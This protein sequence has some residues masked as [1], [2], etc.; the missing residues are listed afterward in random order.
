[1]GYLYSKYIITCKNVVQHSDGT[2]SFERAFEMYPLKKI[3]SK[4]D[5]NLVVGLDYSLTEDDELLVNFEITD[6]DDKIL[7]KNNLLELVPVEY[8]HS[9]FVANITSLKNVPVEKSGMYTIYIYHG[10]RIICK[11]DILISKGS[12]D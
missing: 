1:M 11:Q 5:F 4:L 6:P 10:D 3:P 8:G 7:L 12:D 9:A 2:L